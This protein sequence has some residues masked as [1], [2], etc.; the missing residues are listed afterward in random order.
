MKTEKMYVVHSVAD[1]RTL[2]SNWSMQSH[3]GY[4]DLR[5]FDV[6]YDDSLP[7]DY[8]KIAAAEFDKK[9]LELK[10]TLDV[11]ENKKAELLC[12]PTL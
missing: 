7:E 4:I 5:S 10:A 3:E 12:L 8:A 11:L 1:K 2:L 6:E 9:I